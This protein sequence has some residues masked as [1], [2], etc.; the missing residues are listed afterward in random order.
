MATEPGHPRGRHRPLPPLEVFA[1]IQST[2]GACVRSVV[3][4]AQTFSAIP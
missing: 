4:A 1:P 2:I 3:A